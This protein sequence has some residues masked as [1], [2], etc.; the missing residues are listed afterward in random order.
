MTARL[1]G[2]FISNFEKYAQGVSQEILA[3]SPKK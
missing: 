1:A 2:W 3:A